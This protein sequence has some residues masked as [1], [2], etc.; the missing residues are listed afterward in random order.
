MRTSEDRVSALEA[1]LCLLEDEREIGRLVASYGPFVDSGDAE[2][3]AA[4]W[5]PDG[6]YDVDG[7]Y[8]EGRDDIIAM[9]GSRTHQGFIAGGCA[10]F[11]GP[12]H[13]TVQGDEAT[14]V[15]YSQLILSRDNEF[16]VHRV[17]AHH[18]RFVR[19]D[20]G[21]K[22]SRRTSRALDGNPAAHELLKA[23]T[24]GAPATR[25]TTSSPT[26]ATSPAGSSA[27]EPA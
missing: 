17:T 14:A 19:T 2:A 22:V 27:V 24:R 16:Q 1:R 4:L 6:V 26:A 23:G 20:E 21:W 12:V 9:V 15:S 11:Q 25:P 5:I 3:V 8:M 13:V 7:L 18:W 10:H